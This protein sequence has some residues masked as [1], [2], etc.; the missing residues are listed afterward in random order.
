MEFVKAIEKDWRFLIQ[1]THFGLSAE[2][3]AWKFL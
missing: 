2:N 3:L 1:F